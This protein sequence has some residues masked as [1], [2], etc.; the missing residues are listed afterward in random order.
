M[1][2]S[3]TKNLHVHPEYKQPHFTIFRSNICVVQR[4]L[5]AR[6]FMAKWKM[7]NMMREIELQVKYSTVMINARLGKV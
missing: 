4:M 5:Y 7:A 6:I 1:N 3:I 2:E